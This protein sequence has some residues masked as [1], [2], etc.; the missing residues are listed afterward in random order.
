MELVQVQM[1]NYIHVQLRHLK[2]LRGEIRYRTLVQYL[3]Q[4]LLFNFNN[5]EEVFGMNTFGLTKYLISKS[6]R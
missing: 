4:S 5:Q 2:P 3:G 1:D 6:T